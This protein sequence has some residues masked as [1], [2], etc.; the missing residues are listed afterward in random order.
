[1]TTRDRIH[2]WHS[3]T[4][5]ALIALCFLLPFG[6]VFVVGGCGGT[7]LDSS[8]KFTGAQLVTHTVPH[9]GRDPSCSRDI[10]VC[11]EGSSAT[12][13]E[14]AFGAAIVGLVLGLLGIVRGPGWCTAVGIWALVATGFDLSGLSED[15]VSLHGGYWLA[16]LLFVW[17]GLVHVR[18]ALKRARARSHQTPTGPPYLSEGGPHV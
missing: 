2:R 7:N 5:F 12:A 17:A 14:V 6:T 9:G 4:V 10:S 18:R 8:T 1:M 3:P 16:L 11:V 15:D 13:A